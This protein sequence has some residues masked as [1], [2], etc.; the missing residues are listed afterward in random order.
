MDFTSTGL[1]QTAV[2]GFAVPVAIAFIIALLGAAAAAALFYSPKRKGR[3]Q[4]FMKRLEAHLNFDRMII[5]GILKF[6]YAFTAL[7]SI[8]YGLV[9]LLTGAP[10]AGLLWL[11]LA[12]VSLRVVFEQLLLLLSLREEVAETNDLL[13]RMQGLP[14]KNPPKAE[15]PPAPPRS[16]PVR[17]QPPDP[18]YTQRPAPYPGQGSAYGGYTATPRQPMPVP[19]ESMT[20]RYAPARPAAYAGNGYDTAYGQG[21]P[22]QGMAAPAPAQAST[23]AQGQPPAPVVRPT[24]ADGTGRFQAVPMRDYSDK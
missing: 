13:R 14:L 19:T 8:A 17:P 1:T 15:E 11:L 20:G 10:V 4:G 18:R 22:A 23:P 21:A 5:A 12:P 2:A 7:F 16:Q 24:P 6:L 9:Q 3:Y